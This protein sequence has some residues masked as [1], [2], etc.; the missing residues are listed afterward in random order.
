MG[1]VGLAFWHLRDRVRAGGLFALYLVAA[2][3][4]RFLVEFIRRNEEAALGLTAAQLWA[5]A[6]FVGGVLTVLWFQTRRGG[7]LL[8]GPATTPR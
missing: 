3:L 7:L 4:E 1:L 8:S 5:L 6:L 2:G